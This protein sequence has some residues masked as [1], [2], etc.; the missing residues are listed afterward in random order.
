MSGD[1]HMVIWRAGTHSEQFRIA[2]FSTADAAEA[3]HK[4]LMAMGFTL[5]LTTPCRWFSVKPAKIDSKES[6][7]VDFA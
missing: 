6:V 5:G 7:I 1:V 2:S 4:D 3:Y